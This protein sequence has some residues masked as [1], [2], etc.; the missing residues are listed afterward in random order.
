MKQNDFVYF[1]QNEIGQVKKVFYTSQGDYLVEVEI[2]PEFKNAATE[3]S[4][5][6]IEH[7]PGK[8][9][10]MAVIVEQERPGGTLLKNGTIVE[11][12]ARNEYIKD[13]LS[14]LQKK[15]G[16]AQNE[17][18][19]NFDELKKSLETTSAK[20]D[21]KLETT[22]D[23]LSVQFHS[24]SEELDRVPD[25]QEVK[26]LQENLKKFVEEF[27]QAQKDVQD[28]LRNEI[29]PQL[30]LEMEQLRKLM[31]KEGREKELEKIENQVKELE[32]V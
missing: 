12:S 16:E 18:S 1:Q 20:M 15:A 11:G 26:E 2:E 30:R 14:E 17:L 5:F 25:S 31:K 10:N 19:K 4:Q 13:I 22:L 29:I 23:D 27:N 7:A 6:Y 3:D 32:M 24:F 8:T 21:K 9:T 28:H